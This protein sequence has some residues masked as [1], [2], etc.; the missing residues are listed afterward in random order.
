MILFWLDYYLSRDKT[1][2]LLCVSWFILNMWYFWHVTVNSWNLLWLC[3]VLFPSCSWHRERYLLSWDLQSSK[4]ISLSQVCLGPPV[5]WSR[6]FTNC[7][8]LL[9]KHCLWVSR[10]CESL[11]V[12]C[13]SRH[14]NTYWNTLVYKGTNLNIVNIA[15]WCTLNFKR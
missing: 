3:S 1:C 2:A 9:T 14:I 10:T 11:E 6:S 5:I 13:T 7:W 15:L 4:E 12:P 8:Q